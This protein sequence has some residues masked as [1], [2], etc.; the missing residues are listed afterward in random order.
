VSGS[1]P[2]S[3]SA[4]IVLTV[5]TCLIIGACILA[6]V[7]STKPDPKMILLLELLRDFPRNESEGIG[8]CSASKDAESQQDPA[9]LCREMSP[10]PDVY[11]GEWS[12]EGS[13]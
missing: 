1:F 10:Q 5:A 6:I 12:K 7:R 4:D 2:V 8:R 9:K 13:S 3:D 11:T